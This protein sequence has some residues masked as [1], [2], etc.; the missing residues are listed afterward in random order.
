M[1]VI[2]M[3]RIYGCRPSGPLFRWCQAFGGL[4]ILTGSGLP[5]PGSNLGARCLD[6]I[7]SRGRLVDNI[8]VGSSATVVE[9]EGFE[10]RRGHQ[11]P[12]E[13]INRPR[14]CYITPVLL[15]YQ[16][17]GA[18]PCTRHVWYISFERHRGH[19]GDIRALSR[20]L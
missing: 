9:V 1:L 14:S 20:S 16:W 3:L 15:F 13:F 4:G 8:L 5:R 10:P 7:L 6:L 18:T 12:P 11:S 17:R 2:S 19:F